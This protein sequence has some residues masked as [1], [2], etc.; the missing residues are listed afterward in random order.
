LYTSGCSTLDSE[1][2]SEELL[3]VLDW[4]SH[5]LDFKAWTVVFASANCCEV[6]M[7]RLMSSETALLLLLP[8]D[9]PYLPP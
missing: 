5:M 2:K 7:V 1:R 4:L 8:V 9:W 6:I 3:E